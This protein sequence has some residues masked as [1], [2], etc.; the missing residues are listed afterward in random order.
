MV[1]TRT[2]T[3]IHIDSSSST[4]E[5]VSK[6]AIGTEAYAK[7]EYVFQE[8]LLQS[9]PAYLWY[10]GTY[11]TGCPRPILVRLHHQRQMHDLH[12]ALS[13]AISDIIDRWWS[14]EDAR[15]WER[16]PLKKEEEDLLKWLDDQVKIGNLPPMAE[17]LGSWRPDFLIDD[18]NAEEENYSIT[19]INARYVFN[20]FM[21]LIYGQQALNASLPD[22]PTLVSATDSEMSLGSQ[23][24]VRTL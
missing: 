14:D 3:Q 21:H 19:E 9:C 13:I 22:K 11:T 10:N 7:E 17:Y 20:G 6:S 23:Q 2:L 12:E 16:M 1:S 18:E 4:Y 5:S 15:L 24:L 8:T